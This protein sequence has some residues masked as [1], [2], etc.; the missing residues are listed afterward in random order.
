MKWE[1]TE[2]SRNNFT[3]AGADA[4]VEFA[5]KYKKQIRCHTLVWHSQ[6]PAWVSDGGWDNKTLISIM[7]NHIQK[8]AG[9]YRGKCTH[10]DVVNEG[11]YIFLAGPLSCT[12]TTLTLPHLQHTL[13]TR[14][15]K[16][17]TIK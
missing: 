17:K 2:P 11:E 1:S 6:L 13:P 14:D 15:Q 4:I 10:W 3:F 7:A 9:R 16:R 8:V 5:K 12:K